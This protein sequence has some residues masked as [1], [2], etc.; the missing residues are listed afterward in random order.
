[1][2]TSAKS[3]NPALIL[4]GIIGLASVAIGAAGDHLLAGGLDEHAAEVFHTA[5]RYHQIYA[6]VLLVCAV[7]QLRAALHPA[8]WLFLAGAV[9]F[10]GSLYALSLSGIAAL[11]MLT[12]VGGFLLMAGWG[13]IIWRGVRP[14][15]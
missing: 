12:P 7:P 2:D 9:V 4:A 8:F 3:R 13:A 10:C 11:G 15:S 14:R 5:L 6:V 1:M